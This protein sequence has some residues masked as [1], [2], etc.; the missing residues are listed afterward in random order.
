MRNEMNGQNKIV[1]CGY[2]FT[3]NT[4]NVFITQESNVGSYDTEAEAREAFKSLKPTLNISEY[5][6]GLQR[7]KSSGK[8]AKKIRPKPVDTM[9]HQDYPNGIESI[10]PKT[11]L[12]Q[13]Y[14]SIYD[15]EQAGYNL[16]KI[17]LIFKYRALTHKG[18]RWQTL[19]SRSK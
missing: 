19:K 3:G 10:N 13:E 11:G 17:Y 5:P 2:H 1:G 7:S 15:A 8:N 18:L 6:H 4:W 16:D 9:R 14:P 12:V